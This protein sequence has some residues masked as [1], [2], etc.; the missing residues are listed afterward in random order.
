MSYIAYV[1]QMNL[2]RSS[3]VLTTRRLNRLNSLL[4]QMLD[5][6]ETMAIGSAIT[7][8]FSNCQA[9]LLEDVYQI[10]GGPDTK[11]LAAP[12]GTI[13]DVTSIY[14]GAYIVEITVDHDAIETGLSPRQIRILTPRASGK[15]QAQETA[16]IVSAARGNWNGVVGSVTWTV[17]S[18]TIGSPIIPS[19]EDER[20]E[21][22][23]NEVGEM[24]DAEY[25]REWLRIQEQDAQAEADRLEQ[26]EEEQERLELEDEA[27]AERLNLLYLLEQ[28][29]IARLEI[30]NER[31]SED[32]W[33][34]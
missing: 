1:N 5:A 21:D 23:R 8:N 31:R 12:R 27:E 26:E 2:I 30:E 22:E 19:D 32:G 25:E 4:N 18:M 3:G 33:G 13:V 6:N 24:E 9:V 16:E 17:S 15:L 7:I 34:F 20:D 14:C 11:Y 10:P 28:D 29:E